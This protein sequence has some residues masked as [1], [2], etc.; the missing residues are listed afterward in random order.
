MKVSSSVAKAIPKFEPIEIRIT[1]ESEEEL[2][3][4]WLR[5][6][7]SGKTVDKENGCYLK[8]R[9]Q[10]LDDKQGFVAKLWK[11]LDNYVCRGDLKNR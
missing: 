7:L 2:C 6:N 10:E 5:H 1:V 4:L 3:D 9:S 8:Y 11:T